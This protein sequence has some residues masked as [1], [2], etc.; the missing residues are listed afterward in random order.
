MLIFS[1]CAKPAK[2]KLNDALANTAEAMMDKE[3]F[4]VNAKGTYTNGVANR[5]L[6][7][8][9]VVKMRKTVNG[10]D[11]RAEITTTESGEVKKRA[12]V[13]VGGET[14]VATADESGKFTDWVKLSTGEHNDTDSVLSSLT[15]DTVKSLIGDVESDEVLT[16]K[17]GKYE[18]KYTDDY[19]EQINAL[20]K[21]VTDGEGVQAGEYLAKSLN[22]NYTREAL[23]ADINEIFGDKVTVRAMINGMDGLLSNIGYDKTV[24]QIFNGFC[25]KVNITADDIYRLIGDKANE[26]L[27]DGFT[28]SA[29]SKGETPFDFI[30]S[31]GV[32][33]MQANKL[34]NALELDI[35][36]GEIRE[37]LL[38]V[39]DNDDATIGELY[40]T[41]AALPDSYIYTALSYIGADEEAL[42]ELMNNGAIFGTENLKNYTV[43]KTAITRK[44]VISSKDFT[45]QSF[46]IGVTADITYGSS[47]KLLVKTQ[48]TAKATF[49][50]KSKV[51][52]VAPI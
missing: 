17:D 14:Y 41:V 47:Q 4:T 49:D 44:T 31:T 38:S 26:K 24:K 52:I 33:V 32:G 10:Y 27:P 12:A 3:Y 9:A 11:Y 42:S 37:R 2:I 34:F 46:N 39:L 51:T 48:F 35:T 45:V 18:I 13:S 40:D 50:Y 29:P 20:K 19:G 36:T 15:G 1:A 43:G 23:V 8:S 5:N 21:F 16:E 7:Y 30:M 6:K 28:I 25:R 22:E